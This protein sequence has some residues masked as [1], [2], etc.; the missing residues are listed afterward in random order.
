VFIIVWRT[1]FISA[2][3]A[4]SSASRLSFIKSLDGSSIMDESP[5]ILDRR[6]GRV[7][8]D[9]VGLTAELKAG[10]GLSSERGSLGVEVMF[11]KGLTRAIN[12]LVFSFTGLTASVGSLTSLSGLM[13]SGM[14]FASSTVNAVG[15]CES[16]VISDR[17]TPALFR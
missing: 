10:I 7:G 4:S 12:G 2:S 11:T 16:E 6:E 5:F 1:A 14:D 9:F 17:S 13:A 15:G 3:V 8:L